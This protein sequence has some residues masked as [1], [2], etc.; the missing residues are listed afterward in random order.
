MAAPNFCITFWCVLP[1]LITRLLTMWKSRVIVCVRKVVFP[2]NH[3]ILVNFLSNCNHLQSCHRSVQSLRFRVPTCVWHDALCVILYDNQPN[4]E[5]QV[6]YRNIVLNKTTTSK[7]IF[8]FRYSFRKLNKE[9][10]WSL[11]DTKEDTANGFFFSFC[12]I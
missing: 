4:K 5:C 8:G 11:G 3:R 10:G 2:F 6:E 1:E 7:E 12:C 9:R